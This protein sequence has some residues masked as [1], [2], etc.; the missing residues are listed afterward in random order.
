M[1][2][3]SQTPNMVMIMKKPGPHKILFHS[4]LPKSWVR[5]TNKYSTKP[6]SSPAKKKR[7]QN[8]RELNFQRC[9]IGRNKIKCRQLKKG[10]GEFRDDTINYPRKDVRYTWHKNDIREDLPKGYTE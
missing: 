1:S 5:R 2:P 3:E 6:S 8:Y 7:V 4:R 9:H 10:V